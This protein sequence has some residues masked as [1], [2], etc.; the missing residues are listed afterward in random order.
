MLFYKQHFHK[1]RQAKLKKNQAK[2]KQQLEA[3]FLLFKNDLITL[4]TLKIIGDTVKKTYK[5]QM[6]LF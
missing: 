6:R 3:D 5:K 2:T 4:S 1:E